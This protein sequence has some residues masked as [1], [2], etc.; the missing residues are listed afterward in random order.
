MREKHT[1][2]RV[3]GYLQVWRIETVIYSGLVVNMHLFISCSE[4]PVRDWKELYVCWRM[5]TYAMFGDVYRRLRTCVDVCW[6]ML[7]YADSPACDW[8]EL[9]VCRRML[10]YADVCIY[11]VER[12][13]WA[14]PESVLPCSSPWFPRFPILSLARGRRLWVTRVFVFFFVASLCYC[15]KS[16]FFKKLVEI[17][18]FL[19]QRECV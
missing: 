7:T 16:L 14:R 10:T 12:V 18:Y 13:A 4:S 5:Q 15:C 1:L 8:K 3:I 19:R 11:I 2:T 6:R 17:L 9:Y